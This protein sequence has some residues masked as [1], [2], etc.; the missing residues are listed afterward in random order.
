MFYRCSIAP[1]DEQFISFTLL[2]DTLREHGASQITAILP[3][4]AYARQ[5]KVK[6]GESLAAAWAGSLLKA[7]VPIGS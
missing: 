4:L 5:D 6:E 7:Q 1:P 2:S 3:Y